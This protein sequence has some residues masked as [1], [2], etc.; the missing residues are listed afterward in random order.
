MVFP[1]RYRA[2][3]NRKEFSRD[4]ARQILIESKKRADPDWLL[5]DCLK[6]LDVTAN[7]NKDPGSDCY[8]ILGK[9][10]KIVAFSLLGMLSDSYR[11]REVKNR[12]LLRFD[13]EKAN[14][15]AVRALVTLETSGRIASRIGGRG[16]RMTKSA[17]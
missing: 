2:P 17:P 11:L 9:K 3:Q 6:V 14:I 7:D 4:W 1:A 12:Y 15:D 10:R 5:A 16:S 8:L 13:P